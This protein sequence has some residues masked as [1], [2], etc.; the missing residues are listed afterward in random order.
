MNTIL[1]INIDN[2]IETKQMESANEELLLSNNK[3][4][5]KSKSDSSNT[6]EIDISDKESEEEEDIYE[7]VKI[8]RKAL[9]QL[10]NKV[11]VLK[12]FETLTI[13]GRSILEG[14][15]LHFNNNILPVKFRELRKDMLSK[16]EFKNEQMKLLTKNDLDFIKKDN[17]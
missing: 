12:G 6:K 13:N 11:S 1:E 10:K 14:L 17:A 5:S 3:K 4:S 8:L 16:A 15:T 2:F 7:Q 9:V